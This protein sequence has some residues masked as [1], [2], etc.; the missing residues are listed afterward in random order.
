MLPDFTRIAWSSPQA[1]AVWGAR[2]RQITTAWEQVECLSVL[3]GIRSSALQTVAPDTL[4]AL[5][6]WAA[7]VGLHVV[8]LETTGVSASYAASAVPVVAGQPWAYRVAL[9]T[10]GAAVRWPEAWKAKD[11]DTIGRLLGF[12]LCCRRFF[13]STWATGSVDT[14]WEMGGGGEWV[15]YDQPVRIFK[16]GWWPREANILLRWLGVRAVSHLPCAFDCEDTVTL[17]RDLIACGRRH[18]FTDEMTWL[19]E[20]LDWPV[21]WSALHGIAE[22]V[23]PVCRIQTRTNHTDEKLV[24]RREGRVYPIEGAKGVRFPFTRDAQPLPLLKVDTSEWTDN[25]FSS[26]AAM[27]AAHAMILAQ[28]EGPYRCVLDLGCGN[29]ALL[30]KMPAQRRIGVESDSARVRVARSRL[31]E[32]YSG[33]CTYD[34]L[35]AYI[36]RTE[37][38]DL[39]LAQVHRNS[40]EQ[41]PGYRVLSYSYDEPQFARLIDVPQLVPA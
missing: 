28:L 40:P 3:D 8:P 1:Q 38:P 9:A 6:A 15:D 19:E 35:L 36:V 39:I 24:I 32:V 5:S 41:F 20:M 31:D 23:T 12:P 33:D 34:Q 13:A 10:P 26:K 18:K 29:G 37:H 2:V 17:G 25:G 27:D 30:A 11:N 21:E 14:T 7:S 4:P 22:I 16:A